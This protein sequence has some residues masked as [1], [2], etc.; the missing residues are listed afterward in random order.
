VNSFIN[1]FQSKYNKYW[2]IFFSFVV[3]ASRPSCIQK[4]DCD[5]KSCVRY[6]CHWNNYTLIV[7]CLICRMLPKPNVRNDCMWFTLRLIVRRPFHIINVLHGMVWVWG[8]V[9]NATFNNISII[10]WL[11]VLL[12]D[13]TGVPVENLRPVASHWQTY[14]I[15]FFH[16]CCIEYTS[17][18]AGFELTTLVVIGTDSTGSCKSNYHTIMTTTAMVIYHFEVA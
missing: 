15:M 12:M 7:S 5:L 6:K 11:L 2:Q 16:F 14:H 3:F 10:S 4:I 17:P 9:F 13:E 1:Y 8:M 18:R